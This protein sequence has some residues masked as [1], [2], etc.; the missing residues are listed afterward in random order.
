[1][2]V[3]HELKRVKPQLEQLESKLTYFDGRLRKYWMILSENEAVQQGLCIFCERNWR[4]SELM[5]Q[6]ALSTDLEAGIA[7]RCL[8]FATL[9]AR[10]FQDGKEPCEKMLK[11]VCV[12]NRGLGLVPVLLVMVPGIKK[13]YLS[14]FRI[15][16]LLWTGLYSQERESKEWEGVVRTRRRRCEVVIILCT[17]QWLQMQLRQSL[18]ITY[19]KTKN[20]AWDALFEILRSD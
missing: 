13:D 17:N 6:W 12:D 1:M 4:Q 5:M 11:D 7:R 16:G 9:V 8:H 18:S 3:L 14:S 2:A 15:V 19:I 10:S 20:D